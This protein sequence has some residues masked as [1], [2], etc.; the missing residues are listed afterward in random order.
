MGNLQW[1]VSAGWLAGLV[2]LTPS[3][4]P[5]AGEELLVFQQQMFQIDENQ[6]MSW[7]FENES[8]INGAKGRLQRHLDS[9]L[10]MLASL[11]ELRPEQRK[12]LE[13][14]G[15]GDIDRF[16]TMAEAKL[17]EM[18]RG[19]IPQEEWQKIWQG[20]SPIRNRYKRGVHGSDSLFRRTIPAVLDGEQ[21]EKYQTLLRERANMRYRALVEATVA[22]LEI[23]LPLTSDQRERLIKVI[24]EETTP[25]NFE[26]EN[27][28]KYAVV[29]HKMSKVPEERIKPIFDDAEWKHVRQALQ[30]GAMWGGQIDQLEK[31]GEVDE[32]G[33]IF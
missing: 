13:L 17:R 12:R 6:I 16:F 29:L 4:R 24:L 20:L 15:R 33:F 10:E 27:Y 1:I 2:L 25:P 3:P 8:S 22:Q 26:A 21:A 9:E 14:A 5:A 18:P 30:R 32:F 11:G 31:G 19:S 28:L 7:A 23:K